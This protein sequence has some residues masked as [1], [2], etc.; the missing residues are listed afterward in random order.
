MVALGLAL[1][2]GLVQVLALAV[3][4]HRKQAPATLPISILLLLSTFSL[5]TSQMC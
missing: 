2:P 4:R 1:V 5:L 3:V